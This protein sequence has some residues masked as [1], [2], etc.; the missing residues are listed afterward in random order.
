MLAASGTANAGVENKD[1]HSIFRSEFPHSVEDCMQEEGST[2]RREGVDSKT[3]W[4]TMCMSLETL[5]QV[6]RSD[7]ASK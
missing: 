4:H 2:G 1:A 5:L 3:D 7:L 6:L